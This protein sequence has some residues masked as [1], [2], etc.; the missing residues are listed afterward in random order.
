ME[1]ENRTENDRQE[2]VQVKLHFNLRQTKIDTPTLIYGV[3]TCNGQQYKVATGL[4]VYP[5][6]WDSQRQMAVESNLLSRRDN[7][8]NH[9]INSQIETLKNRCN[10]AIQEVEELS[11]VSIVIGRESR[12]IFTN[13]RKHFR[14]L[15]R[16]ENEG[17]GII[18][19][20]TETLWKN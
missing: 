6:Q 15:L 8:N 11:S 16:G 4:K 17:L 19:P 3:Y 14:V 20:N 13:I 12:K 7:R 9:I 18:V 2:F 5:S 10:T 1:T